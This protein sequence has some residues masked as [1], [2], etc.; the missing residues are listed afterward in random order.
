[1]NISDIGCLDVNCY[2]LHS[3]AS[4]TDQCI[5]LRKW[6]IQDFPVR[7]LFR[8]CQ[9]YPFGKLYNAVQYLSEATK[10]LTI[11]VIIIIR[12]C[13]SLKSFIPFLPFFFFFNMFKNPKIADFHFIVE[14]HFLQLANPLYLKFEHFHPFQ[15]QSP[16]IPKIILPESS[17][18]LEKNSLMFTHM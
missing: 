4:I 13:E 12:T 15:P 14:F 8:F 7:R 3:I 16:K 10:V 6:Y 1:M 2:I 11:V 5:T 9:I 17:S 18:L